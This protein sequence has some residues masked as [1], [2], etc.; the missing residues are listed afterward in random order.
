M[1]IKANASYGNLKKLI[2]ALSK[3]YQIKVGVLANKAGIDGKTR[4]STVVSDDMDV[5]GV[6]ALQE[7]GA[8]IKITKKMAAF[9]HFKAEDLGLPPSNGKGDG[10]IHIPARSWLQI[11]LEKKN[12]LKKKIIEKFGG[13]QES[14]ENYIIETGDLM[15]LAIIIG[16]SAVEQI[17]E[18]FASEGFGQWAPNSPLTVASKG[19]AMP[20]ID[21]GRVRGAITYE[22]NNNG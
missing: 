9:L 1:E 7:F 6:G 14:I 22:V 21:K 10:Y 15:S 17:Q 3:D 11:P 2:Q 13:E 19:S 16:V 8:D 4:G 18:A 12:A 20:L 5:A